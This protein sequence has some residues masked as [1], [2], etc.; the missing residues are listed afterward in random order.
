MPISKEYS[1]SRSALPR[2]QHPTVLKYTLRLE[3]HRLRGPWSQCPPYVT[4]SHSACQQCLILTANVGDHHNE[5]P[6][7]ECIG[8][9]ADVQ[10]GHV[11][12]HPHFCLLPAISTDRT[13]IN[14]QAHEDWVRAMQ[15]AAWHWHAPTAIACQDSIPVVHHGLNESPHDI[16][17]GVFIKPQRGTL[18]CEGHLGA[19]K[20]REQKGLRRPNYVTSRA[21]IHAHESGTDDAVILSSNFGMLT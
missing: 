16:F 3:I 9:I 13:L 21:S 1:Q 4:Q 18:H 10:L 6:P 11:V 15:D 19:L 8:M 7:L 5:R 14:R 17:T 12:V 2:S 20:Q